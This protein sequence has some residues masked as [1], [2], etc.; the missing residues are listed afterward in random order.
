MNAVDST[1]RNSVD[2]FLF[3]LG[4]LGFLLLDAGIIIGAPFV[5]IVGG[6]IKLFSILTF[7]LRR[8]PGE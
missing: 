8:S 7:H 6:V 4:F 2:F 1:D 3:G 5:A